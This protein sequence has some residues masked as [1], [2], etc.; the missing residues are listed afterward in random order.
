MSLGHA[1]GPAPFPSIYF[2]FLFE[3]RGS[4]RHHLMTVAA[5]GLLVANSA[6]APVYFGILEKIS[7]CSFEAA[8]NS[9]ERRDFRRRERWPSSDTLADG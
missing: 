9:G 6:S 7:K 3:E 2:P 1:P 5:I 8:R 4:G